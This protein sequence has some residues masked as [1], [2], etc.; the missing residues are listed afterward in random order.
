MPPRRTTSGEKAMQFRLQMFRISAFTAICAAVC[1]LGVA[2][3]QPNTGTTVNVSERE[4]EITLDRSSASAGKVTFHVTNDGTVDHEF[5]VVKTDLGVNDLP[6]KDDGTFD[7]SGAG[8]QVIDELEMIDAGETMDLT[9][10][11]LAAGKYVLIC[12]MFEAGVAH[13][14]RGMRVAFTVN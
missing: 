8:V 13:F 5:V 3:P 14:Q 1:S 7:E 9:I 10:D 2:C 4:F 12:N 11:N 6:T